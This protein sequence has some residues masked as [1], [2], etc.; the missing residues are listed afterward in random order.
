LVLAGITEKDQPLCF[1]RVEDL[2]KP[3]NER[4]HSFWR[5]SAYITSGQ[6]ENITFVPIA[7]ITSQKY[8]IYFEKK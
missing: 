5:G 6:N 8:S 4:H 3:L 7:T 2:L 1:E